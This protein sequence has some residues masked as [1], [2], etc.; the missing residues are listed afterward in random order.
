MMDGDPQPTIRLTPMAPTDCP[1][2]ALPARVIM[3]QPAWLFPLMMLPVIKAFAVQPISITGFALMPLRQLPSI[4]RSVSQF[5][6]EKLIMQIGKPGLHPRHDAQNSLPQEAIG[7]GEIAAR[8]V[9]HRRSAKLRE[10]LVRI[11]HGSVS[12]SQCAADA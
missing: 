2:P 11:G 3:A 1:D 5:V 9:L 12:K 10:R 6:V 7:A 8:N 4:K